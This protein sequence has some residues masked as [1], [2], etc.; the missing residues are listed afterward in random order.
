VGTA[1]G[2]TVATTSVSSSTSRTESA[3]TLAYAAQTTTTD[4]LATGRTLVLTVGTD[5][6][7]VRA[8]TVAAP[9]GTSTS[10]KSADQTTCVA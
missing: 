6:K 1:K 4:T 2:G 9:S 10:V 8:V 3:R 7:G 5:W